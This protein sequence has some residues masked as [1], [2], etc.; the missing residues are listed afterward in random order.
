MGLRSKQKCPCS[1]AHH[2]AVAGPWVGQAGGVANVAA[3]PIGLHC[4]DVT[5]E[6]LGQADAK[7]LFRERVGEG[8]AIGRVGGLG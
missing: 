6:V 3:S 5:H 8:Q 2:G 1:C 4:L 7:D